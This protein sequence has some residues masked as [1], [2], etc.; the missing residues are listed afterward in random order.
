VLEHRRDP[1][2]RAVEQLL[3]LLGLAD[4]VDVLRPRVGAELDRAARPQDRD[5]EHE[6]EQGAHD[7]G[8]RA[9][10]EARAGECSNPRRSK[11]N[12]RPAP[13]PAGASLLGGAV[14]TELAGD[15]RGL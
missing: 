3:R 15:A 1:P 8:A 5:Q 2:A 11:A 9:P 4:P 14:A 13:G 6:A 10:P 12:F 7:A